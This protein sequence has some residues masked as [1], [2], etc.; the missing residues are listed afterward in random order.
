M[1][2][3]DKTLCIEK[4]FLKEIDNLL[5]KGDN[6]SRKLAHCV[7]SG[8]TGSG[9]SSLLKRLLKKHL[10]R[11]S[12][13]TGVIEKM[14][15]VDMK[16]INP[17][18]FHS[19]TAVDFDLWK[20]V[21]YDV[22]LVSQIGQSSTTPTPASTQLPADSEPT[23]SAQAKPL[24]EDVKPKQVERTRFKFLH[25]FKRKRKSASSAV[26]LSHLE[27]E[28]VVSVVAVSSDTIL[29]VIRRHGFEAFKEYF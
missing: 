1:T 25:I 11:F 6:I 3:I 5:E 10:K 2:L 20:E 28:E 27:D 13:S 29:P 22:S 17:T 7:I 15:F 9:K 12:K 4:A 8:P 16:E 21:D 14:V 26:P 19:A 18:T 24:L 23:A